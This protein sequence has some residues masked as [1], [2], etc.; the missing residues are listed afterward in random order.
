MGTHFSPIQLVLLKM[1]NIAEFP[2]FHQSMFR[3]A[4]LSGAV[5]VCMGAVGGH[6][7]R[8][9]CD[10]NQWED[11]QTANKYHITHSIAL[12][13]AACV[14]KTE[15]PSSLFLAGLLSF[16]V[17]L[18]KQ[19]ITGKANKF[20]RFIKPWGGIFIIGGWLSL[21]ASDMLKI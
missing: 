15:V 13:I 6:K 10:K 21:M 20:E 8:H 3:V 5:S 19:S 17:P 14:T 2:N 18:Y 4:A 1:I 7:V 11:F 12:G 9:H 16:C